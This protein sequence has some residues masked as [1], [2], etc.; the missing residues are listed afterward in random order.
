MAG[1]SP[2]RLA[3]GCHAGQ[4]LDPPGVDV[5]HGLAKLVSEVAARQ[6]LWRTEISQLSEWVGGL[7]VHELA[8]SA[9][10]RS[11]SGGLQWWP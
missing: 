6:V 5:V 7:L 4:G 10:M 8:P 9:V 2:G 1:R 3:C 11:S